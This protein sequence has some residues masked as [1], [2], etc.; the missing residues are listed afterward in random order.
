V[1]R[2]VY[3]HKLKE[4]KEKPEADNLQT[5]FKPN[6]TDAMKSKVKVKSHHTGIYQKITFKRKDETEEVWSWSCC[7]NE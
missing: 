1:F 2:I 5:T 6:L 4:N 7:L 3:E